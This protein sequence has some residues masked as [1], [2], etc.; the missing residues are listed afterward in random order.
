MAPSILRDGVAV[1]VDLKPMNH[2]PLVVDED[3]A[4]RNWPNNRDLQAKWLDAVRWMQSR[5]GGSIWVIDTNRPLPKWH[6]L[7]LEELR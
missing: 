6:G 5:P 2:A 7:P 1:A 4:R 3:R